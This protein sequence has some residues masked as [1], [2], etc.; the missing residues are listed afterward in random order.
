MKLRVFWFLAPLLGFCAPLSAQVADLYLDVPL[1]GSVGDGQSTFYRL[2]AAAPLHLVLTLQNDHGWSRHALYIQRDVLPTTDSYL[3]SSQEGRP[4]QIIEI[5]NLEPGSY[6]V[7]VRGTDTFFSGGYSILA[8]T[9]EQLPSLVLDEALA[10][11]VGDAQS[12]FYRLEMPTS[13]HLVLTLQND[14]GWS[15][16]ALY[17]QRDVLPTT[18]YYLGSSAGDAPE[19]L[20]EI[21][22]LEAG[23]YYV[24]VRGVD[25]FFSGGYSIL[26]TD[27]DHP[28][29]EP[30]STLWVSTYRGATGAHVT[31][32]AWAVGLAENARVVLA[33]DDGTTIEAEVTPELEGYLAARFNLTGA[34]LGEYDLVAINPDGREFAALRPFVIESEPVVELWADIVGRDR[35]RVGRTSTFVVRYGNLG[36]VDVRHAYVVLALPPHVPFDIDVPWAWTPS[37]P[38]PIPPSGDDAVAFIFLDL[39]PLA[40]GAN[41]WV[42]VNVAPDTRG[43]FT[44]RARITIDPSPYFQSMLSLADLIPLD[45]PPPGE[46]ASAEQSRECRAAE[47][48]KYSAGEILFWAEQDDNPLDLWYGGKNNTYGYHIAKS[49]G[50]GW[51]IDILD[52]GIQIR[53]LDDDWRNHQ[54]KFR[55]FTP[56]N[57]SEGHRDRVDKW[58]DTLW[59]L[60]G[61][62]QDKNKYVTDFCAHKDTFDDGVLKT[63][64]EGVFHLLNPEY[65]DPRKRGNEPYWKGQPPLVLAGQIYDF[66]WDYSGREGEAWDKFY[67]SK[68]QPTKR[69]GSGRMSGNGDQTGDQTG[70][71]DC[72]KAGSDLERARQK[73]IDAVQAIDPNEMA[74]P[75]GFGTGGFIP[76]GEEIM[77]VIY[78]ENVESATAPAQEVVITDQLDLVTLDGDALEL[79]QIAFGDTV[80]D[81]PPRLTTY[82]TTIDLRPDQNL[83]LRVEA[84]LDQS[85][86]QL[87][88]TFTSVDPETG[89][90]PEDPLAGFLPPN[91]EPPEG[92]GYV[93]FTIRQKPD[94]ASGTQIRN[95]ATIVFDVNPPIE[96]R[97]V[98][99][100]IDAGAPSS[101]VQTLEETQANAEFEVSWSGEDDAGGSGIRDYTIY[102]ATDDS[103]YTVWLANTAETSA[104]FTGEHRHTYRFYSRA[105]DNVGHVEPAPAD[106]DARTAVVLEAVR[107]EPPPEPEPPQEPGPTPEPE[108]P[109]GQAIPPEL[110][111]T[112]MCGACG[113][114]ASVAMIMSFCVLGFLRLQRRREA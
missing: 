59:E 15:R 20:I 64:C 43:P 57:D 7:M 77:Y 100:T 76:V 103:P 6:Y 21:P 19:Q 98:L 73:V 69:K 106:A 65:G 113:S 23:P 22:G 16:H 18:D 45:T 82:S 8:R 104:T 110:P 78:F 34:A 33:R 92:E 28:Q 71:W 24:L 39:P 95:K 85:S 70:Y 97:E 83:T 42:S 67:S 49:I 114:G 86:G 35:I 11:G 58:A 112:P 37:S 5:P 66:L 90:L 27:L 12:R 94:L 93:M 61:K 54:G 108:P 31:V 9:A 84:E 62:D 60:F 68:K 111:S 53:C 55:H 10:D 30:D 25:T 101:A 50:G 109:P 52:D 1:T 63:N 14:H 32:R 38:P 48:D 88:W 40:A 81:V 105:T 44:V 36:N 17:I 47:E 102:V 2:N 29:P 51:F 56:P 72:P 46:T 13:G 74:G 107:P 41:G 26:A 79:G 3:A 91:R 87:T 80:I 89:E 96:T 4:E 99:N 75:A